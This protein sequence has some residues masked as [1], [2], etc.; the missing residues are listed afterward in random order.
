MAAPSSPQTNNG[1]A[2]GIPA[3][4]LIDLLCRFGQ[5]C[6]GEL[7]H[8]NFVGTDVIGALPGSHLEAA[9]LF[10]P[11]GSFLAFTSRQLSGARGDE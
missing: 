2:E 6:M 7:I 3:A 4:M 8:L 11:R 5:H 1:F 10:L 9:S